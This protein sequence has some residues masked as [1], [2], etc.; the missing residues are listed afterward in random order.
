MYYLL[1][2]FQI[3]RAIDG[4]DLSRWIRARVTVEDNDG[5]VIIF[6]D[7][8]VSELRKLKSKY[9]KVE[10][11]NDNDWGRFLEPRNDVDEIERKEMLKILRGK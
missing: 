4:E 7:V 10:I 8:G 9:K 1:I 5:R 2:Y 6:P 11:L 3:A